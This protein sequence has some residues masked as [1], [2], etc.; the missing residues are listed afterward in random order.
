MIH[1]AWLANITHMSGLTLLRKYLRSHPKERNWRL[2]CMVILFVLLL[3]AEIP[4]AF[5]NWK[6]YD[7]EYFAELSAAN[8]TSYAHC[9]FNMQIAR[10][11]F[12]IAVRNSSREDPAKYDP[13]TKH[14]P[15][16]SAFQSLVM[17]V[18]LLVFNF[19][20]RLTKIMDKPST[21][22]TTRLR[23][24]LSRW[25]RK[26]ALLADSAFLRSSKLWTP[27]K[28]MIH[29]YF[30]VKQRLAVLLLLRLYADIYTS[31]L[32]EVII[33]LDRAVHHNTLTVQ[34]NR[35]TGCF[36]PPFGPSPAF[37]WSELQW[38]LMRMR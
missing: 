14:L 7:T 24:P 9:F 2:L 21:W 23:A 1:L 4:T 27:R 29:K 13:R 15:D 38:T 19:F 11:R 5:F 30:S 34:L 22:A 3:V 28:I 37:S 35:Y 31:M 18:L 36:Y 12:E 8:A 25:W 33:R 10:E 17:T 20:T 26:K 16:T 32:S 6:S